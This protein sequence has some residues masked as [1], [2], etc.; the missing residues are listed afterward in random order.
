[1]SPFCFV[2]LLLLP[3]LCESNVMM[4]SRTAEAR[5]SPLFP[6]RGGGIRRKSRV[7]P[8]KET[9]ADVVDASAPAESE[10]CV[11]D[12]DEAEEPVMPQF[13]RQAVSKQLLAEE[14]NEIKKSQQF[15]QKQQRR[16]ELDKTWLDKGITAVIEFFENLFR[17]E[18]I[19]V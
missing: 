5:A 16:R 19:E 11:V 12:D 14:V 8:A 3:F 4:Y 10:N 2:F 1:M 18:V 9:A 13:D 15:L 17:W 6:P 7:P